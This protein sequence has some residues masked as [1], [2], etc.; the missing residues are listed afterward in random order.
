[1]FHKTTL[2]PEMPIIYADRLTKLGL[3]S[4][5]LRR[6]HLDLIL[7][8]KIVFGV[9]NVS[10]NDFFSHLARSQKKG[11][12][13]Y[14]AIYLNVTFCEQIKKEEEKKTIQ[15]RH[16]ICTNASR[17]LTAIAESVVYFHI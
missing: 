3:Y 6:L 1:M 9:V 14:M 11:V 5:E 12:T 17:G 8:Y 7:C 10:I 13:L 4:L 2:W 16:C 15:P